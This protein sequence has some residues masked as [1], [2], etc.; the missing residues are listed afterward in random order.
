MAL[1]Q[2]IAILGA[3]HVVTM[4]SFGA[5]EDLVMAWGQHGRDV[6]TN[7]RRVYAAAV[8]ACT[9]LGGQAKANLGA[10]Q[11]DV[12]A[13]GDRCYSYLREHGATVQA[14]VEA[15]APLLTAMAEALFPR[16]AEVDEAVGFSEGGAAQQTSPPS[17]SASGTAAETSAGSSG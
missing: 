6:E 8:G 3:Q 11:Y 15:G 9:G 16:A 14:I 17:K 10:M 13:Y 12:L 1:P 2:T 7:A 4:P 5:R